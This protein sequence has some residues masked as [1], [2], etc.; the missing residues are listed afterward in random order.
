MKT[1]K[2]IGLMSGTSLDGL[3]LA[4]CH[5]WETASGW[6]FEIKQTHSIS[7][8]EELQAKLKNSIYLPAD[9]LLQFHNTYGS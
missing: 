9:Q 4:Y 1:Y 2:V 8:S 5:I 3:D 6:N 7:Y